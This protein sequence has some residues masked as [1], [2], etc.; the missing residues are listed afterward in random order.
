M[1]FLGV[2]IVIV[3]GGNTFVH[4]QWLMHAVFCLVDALLQ[5]DAYKPLIH[6]FVNVSTAKMMLIRERH[7]LT[8][9]IINEDDGVE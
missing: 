1:Y 6:S 4:S 7:W 8:M 2:R 3:G 5:E 9:T